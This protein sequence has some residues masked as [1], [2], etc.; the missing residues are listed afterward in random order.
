MNI[1]SR[2]ERFMSTFN[3]ADFRF[4][5]SYLP[6]CFSSGQDFFALS[7]N[8]PELLI[9]AQAAQALGTY[10]SL[11]FIQR[12]VKRWLVK[13]S[14]NRQLSLLPFRP[15]ISSLLL[16]FLHPRT[17]CLHPTLILFTKDNSLLAVASIRSLV[18]LGLRLAPR[19]ELCPHTLAVTTYIPD[20]M[21]ISSLFVDSFPP[22]SF[23]RSS[24][25]STDRSSS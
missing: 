13:L 6:R 22:T 20:A 3:I 19:Q 7:D 21:T 10:S 12:Q 11:V 1:D 8:H 2:L 14:I 5:P 24:R 16:E 18:D 9:H 4:L 25:F 23:F 15:E 17:V